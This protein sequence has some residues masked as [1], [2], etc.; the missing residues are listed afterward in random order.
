[1]CGDGVVDTEFGET[2]DDGNDHLNDSCPSGPSGTCQSAT[3][4]DGF[5]WDT[6]GGIETCEPGQVKTLAANRLVMLNST[7]S[8]HAQKC[9]VA[10]TRRRA[11]MVRLALLD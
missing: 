9:C 1:M 10:M 4:G 6:D 8:R 2:C 7:A 5:I 3:C 11:S